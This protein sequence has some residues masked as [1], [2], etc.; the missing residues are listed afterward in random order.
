MSGTPS[1]IRGAGIDHGRER[2]RGSP[3]N[4]RAGSSSRPARSG[5]VSSA[6]APGIPSRSRAWGA[7]RLTASRVVLRHG[8]GH[9][10]GRVHN[11]RTRVPDGCHRWPAPTR[12]PRLSHR[13]APQG[14]RRRCRPSQRCPHSP[15]HACRTRLDQDGRRRT[16]KLIDVSS[17]GAPPFA[18]RDRRPLAAGSPSAGE[19][20]TWCATST[21]A[22]PYASCC[23]CGRTT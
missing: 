8:V 5:P 18:C 15:E 17:T 2:E 12:T 19:G 7:S 14:L 6:A 10:G 20:P 4:R 16:R 9:G 21:G 13:L 22:W 23:P 1:A 3:G 11:G